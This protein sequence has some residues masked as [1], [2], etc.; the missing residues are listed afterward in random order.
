MDMTLDASY[1]V[2]LATAN[3]LSTINT[4]LLSRFELFHVEAPA[5]REAV[6]IARAVGK[7]V[8]TELKLTRR[9]K[10]PAGEVVQQMA[11]LGSPRRMH[12]AF[13]AAVGRA[14]LDRR[15]S[16]RVEDLVEEPAHELHHASHRAVH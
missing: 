6:A 14:V 4:S 1:V 15:A 5:P 16:L 9:F 12:K 13:V 3:R 8:L 7:H 11:L 2:Y 10:A